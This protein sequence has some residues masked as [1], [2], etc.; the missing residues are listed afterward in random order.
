MLDHDSDSMLFARFKK[1]NLPVTSSGSTASKR[2]FLGIHYHHHHIHTHA[3]LMATVQVNRVTS[4]IFIGIT[5]I[6]HTHEHLNSQHKI[7]MDLKQFFT[8]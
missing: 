3:V 5:E 2:S 8:G 4:F 6:I 1:V 7:P